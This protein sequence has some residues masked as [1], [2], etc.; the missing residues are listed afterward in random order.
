MDCSQFDVSSGAYFDLH[1]L[2]DAP[3]TLIEPTALGLL[4]L[5]SCWQSRTS[6]H[7]Q[8]PPRRPDVPTDVNRSHKTLRVVLFES[9]RSDWLLASKVAEASPRAY[10][11]QQLGF[12][13]TIDLHPDLLL[14]DLVC[15]PRQVHLRRRTEC[16]YLIHGAR[17]LVLTARRQS[18][19]SRRR[20]L[21]RTRIRARC[22][23]FPETFDLG[24]LTADL[25]C[26]PKQLHL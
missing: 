26:L 19:R 10:P 25:L 4:A 17:L 7:H 11:G 12:P 15:L 21:P 8:P 9:R 24:K 23:G 3:K 13:K 14:V 16:L 2:I 1:T 5:A 18:R 6:N 22:D 20:D